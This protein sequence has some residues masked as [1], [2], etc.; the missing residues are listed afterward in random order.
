M[1]NLIDKSNPLSLDHRTQPASD[2]S[3]SYEV[4]FEDEKKRVRLYLGDC[5]DVMQ[6]APEGCVDLI[7]ADP[8]YFL[9]N[10]GITCYAGKMVSVNKGKWDRSKGFEQNFR[11]TTEWLAACQRVLKPNGTIWVS[12]T[13]HVIHLVGVAMQWLGYKI[14]NDISWEKPNPPPNLSCRYFVHATETIIWAAKNKKSKHYFDYQL[15]KK[16][17]GGKQMKSVW[18][19]LPP[20]GFEKRYGKH[21]TQKPEAL[22]DR[23]IL[24]SSRP[25]DFVLDPFCGSDTTGVCTVRHGRK[26]IGIE[27]EEGWLVVARQ[28]LIDELR[29]TTGPRFRQQNLLLDID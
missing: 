19:I 7:F 18:R 8:P 23:I 10:D 1:S 4:Y 13:H 21:P 12:G 25:G 20:N 5:L 15:M 22:L 26:H 11:F 27:I 14:L 17:S 2:E 6:S 9:S 24:A 29:R 16:L 3:R 28:R